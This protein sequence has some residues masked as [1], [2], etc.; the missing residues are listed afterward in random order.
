[1]AT[2]WKR[3]R[4]LQKMLV[5]SG[6]T[7]EEHLVSYERLFFRGWW[8]ISEVALYLSPEGGDDLFRLPFEAIHSVD[9]T[10]GKAA[11]TIRTA[12]KTFLPAIH[13]RG[14]SIA[15]QLISLKPPGQPPTTIG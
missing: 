10:P 2:R 3:R 12:D 13:P 8:A 15:Q 4:L 11:V 1:M 6:M 7:T 5:A 14:S 9:W